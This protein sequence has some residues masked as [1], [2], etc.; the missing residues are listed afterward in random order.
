MTQVARVLRAARFETERNAAVLDQFSAALPSPPAARPGPPP[1][2]KHVLSTLFS[3]LDDSASTRYAYVEN[4]QE[5]HYLYGLILPLTARILAVSCPGLLVVVQLPRQDVPPDWAAPA[6]DDGYGSHRSAG[7]SGDKSTIPSPAGTSTAPSPSDAGSGSGTGSGGPR[8]STSPDAHP[9][10]EELMRRADKAL[11]GAAAAVRKQRRDDNGQSRVVQIQNPARE[12]GLSP[13]PESVVE[14]HRILRLICNGFEVLTGKMPPKR[15][16]MGPSTLATVRWEKA[17]IVTPSDPTR[18]VSMSFSNGMMT[19]TEGVVV[20]FS[21]G[22]MVL[23][24]VRDPISV[25]DSLTISNGTPIVAFSFTSPGRVRLG[26]ILAEKP[27]SASREASRMRSILERTNA[28]LVEVGHCSR[29]PSPSGSLDGSVEGEASPSGEQRN[30]A[31]RLAPQVNDEEIGGASSADNNVVETGASSQKQ[32]QLQIRKQQG[33]LRRS[34][35]RVASVQ[36]GMVPRAV[37]LFV[38]TI[39]ETFLD[40]PAFE[41]LTTGDRNAAVQSE[42]IRGS[43]DGVNNATESVDD[44]AQSG[45][46]NGLVPV[47]QSAEKRT[48][49]QLTRL[50]LGRPDTWEREEQQ[51]HDI[52][53]VKGKAGDRLDLRDERDTSTAQEKVGMREKHALER[54]GQ[55]SGRE[56]TPSPSPQPVFQQQERQPSLHPALAHAHPV[57][58]LPY[59]EHPPYPTHPLHHRYQ[60]VP[61]HAASNHAPSRSE[62]MASAMV[63]TPTVNSL[64]K[65]ST[66]PMSSQPHAPAAPVYNY[67]GTNAVY[68]AEHAPNN[69]H[70]SAPPHAVIGPYG[71]PSGMG[72]VPPPHSAPTAYYHHHPHLHPSHAVPTPYPIAGAYAHSPYFA[73]Q[74]HPGDMPSTQ[75]P[76]GMHWHHAVPRPPAMHATLPAQHVSSVLQP[77]HVPHAATAEYAQSTHIYHSPQNV[78]LPHG[79]SQVPLQSH[80]QLSASMGVSHHASPARD[81]NRGGVVGSNYVAHSTYGGAIE[82]HRVP[83]SHYDGHVR[84]LASIRHPLPTRAD[85]NSSAKH[86]I[87][88]Q[89]SSDT[90]A[91]HVPNGDGRFLGAESDMATGNG[92][93]CPPTGATSGVGRHRSSSHMQGGSEGSDLDK[94]HALE[95]LICMQRAGSQVDKNKDAVN[96]NERVMASRS[97]QSSRTNSTVSGNSASGKKMTTGAGGDK[98]NMANHQACNGSEPFLKRSRQH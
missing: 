33:L 38:N 59:H 71:V 54:G 63:Q 81:D 44:V 75:Q 57:H 90:V 97:R 42:T 12:R 21:N 86:G 40:H 6:S 52:K 79:M 10:T 30:S 4:A 55:A 53:D 94:E 31:A 37:P 18:G 73:M 76:N 84:Q 78:P 16:S 64:T 96:S 17:G 87:G 13:P 8:A 5:N 46:S 1:I 14:D 29:E 98:S 70:S 77:H 34:L 49:T 60:P 24:T 89:Q 62:S 93:C 51:R 39:H 22:S 32:Q 56:A 85:V 65:A 23:L 47:L 72:P 61:V 19:L 48:A 7:D 88:A 83:H 91:H 2:C 25:L 43:S 58:P 45:S 80:A 28:L 20:T 92:Y 68:S 95:A 27:E 36:I 26:D 41:P 15:A 11:S 69:G 67:Y 35:A 50:G 3:A 66:A 82:R 9:G 74:A